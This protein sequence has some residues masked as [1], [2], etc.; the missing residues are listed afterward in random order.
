MEKCAFT[1]TFGLEGFWGPFSQS[2]QV[3]FTPRMFYCITHHS[4]ESFIHLKTGRAQDAQLQGSYENWYFHLDIS[5]C[6]FTWID[7]QMPR[8]QQEAMASPHCGQTRRRCRQVAMLCWSRCWLFLDLLNH[9]FFR[10]RP[11]MSCCKI[12]H[13]KTKIT[14]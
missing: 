14:N 4:S 13:W 9:H 10:Q 3:G 8:C 2:N 7:Q 11:S 6:M 12:Y 5:R 1:N